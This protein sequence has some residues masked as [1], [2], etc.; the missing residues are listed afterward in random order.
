MKVSYRRTGGFAPI[1]VSCILDTDTCSPED[2][3][4]LS[5]LVATSGV[6]QATSKTNPAARDVRL[7]TLT[8]NDADAV[9]EVVWDDISIPQ[10]ARPLIQFMQ[11]RAKTIFGDDD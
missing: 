11:S 1:P 7:H 5:R 8:I 9:K 3:Q 10:D 2:A 6:M 4:E